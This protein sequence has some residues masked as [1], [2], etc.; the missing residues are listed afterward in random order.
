MPAMV[1]TIKSAAQR[2]PL[3]AIQRPARVWVVPWS[4]LVA[5]LLVVMAPPPVSDRLLQPRPVPGR[6]ALGKDP[7]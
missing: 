3:S 4:E 5:V 2:R 7:A 6:A 1:P